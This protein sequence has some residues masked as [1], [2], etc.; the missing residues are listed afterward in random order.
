MA[1]ASFKINVNV[2]LRDTDERQKA[3]RWFGLNLAY[4]RK[5]KL[6]LYRSKASCGCGDTITLNAKML[7]SY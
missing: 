4:A 6:T 5:T 7:N 3:E 1:H 2:A